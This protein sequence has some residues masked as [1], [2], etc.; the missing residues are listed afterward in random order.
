MVVNGK[1]GQPV[2]EGLD[3]AQRVSPLRQ[4]TSALGIEPFH[5]WE[6][7]FLRALSGNGWPEGARGRR[8]GRGMG[9]PAH[10][11]VTRWVGRSAE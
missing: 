5:E 8:G 11:G 3:G 1:S 4:P 10:V 6:L 7:L 9:I 2:T